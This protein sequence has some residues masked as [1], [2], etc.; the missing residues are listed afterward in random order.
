MYLG[1]GPQ[2]AL[3][4]SRLLNPAEGKKMFKAAIGTLSALVLISMT[5]G[6]ANAQT[7]VVDA[8]KGCSKEIETYCS[9]VTP[10]GGRLVSCARAHED[11]L[12]LETLALTLS[13]VVSQ[14][15][16]DALKFC[17]DVELGEQRVLNCLGENKASLNKYC[18]LA[19]SDISTN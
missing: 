13:Y 15:A 17:P 5:L 10:G 2:L 18:S 16:A 19:L 3:P 7:P 8:L 12:W 9:T 1:H 4:W 11:K 6:A 14:C